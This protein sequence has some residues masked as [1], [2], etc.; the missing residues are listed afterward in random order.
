LGVF[1]LPPSLRSLVLDKHDEIWYTSPYWINEDVVLFA[2]GRLTAV[3]PGVALQ[4]DN[5]A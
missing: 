3:Y 1:P 4:L 5:D 2:K